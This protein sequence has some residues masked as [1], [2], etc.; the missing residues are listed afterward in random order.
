ME[1]VLWSLHITWKTA[2]RFDSILPTCTLFVCIF[3]DFKDHDRRKI[4]GLVPLKWNLKDI[5]F[6]PI[7]K[8][9]SKDGQK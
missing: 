9:Q 7:F 3:D 6:L 5:W 1:V 8:G 2:L 4:R